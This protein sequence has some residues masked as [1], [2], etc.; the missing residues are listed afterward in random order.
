MISS[1]YYDPTL[2]EKSGRYYVRYYDPG[3]QPCMVERALGTSKKRAAEK[4]LQERSYAYLHGLY[5]PWSEGTSNN[6]LLSEAIEKYLC[7]PHLRESTVRSKRYRLEPLSRQHPYMLVSGLTENII[8]EYCMRSDL[9]SETRSRYLYE[10]RKFLAFCGNQNWISA[11]PAKNILDS[12]PRHVKREKRTVYE[13]L[14]HEEVR[15]LIRAIEADIEMN[16]RRE[17][18][19]ILTDIILI[20]VTTGLRRGELCGLRWTDVRF[21]HSARLE[22]DESKG[23]GWIIVRGDESR[24]TK[25]GDEDRVPLVELSYE[26][27]NTRRRHSQSS[28]FVFESPRG[29]GQVDGEWISKM[30][31]YYRRLAKLPDSI[32]FHSLRHT[33]ASWLA[34]SGVDIKVIQEILRH[35]NLKQ[36][37]RY[38]HLQPDYVAGQ[39]RMALNK[40][41]AL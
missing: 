39:A 41:H 21:D 23:Y 15:R 1:R 7:D 17:N 9:K 37:L 5:D 32:H 28:E 4:F 3:K 13:F 31:R 34:G 20:A 29:T 35:T 24:Q 19:R 33:C 30:F 27:L 38:M 22:A 40:F 18:R 16:P 12:L 10:I 14:T 11:N 25:T 6:V 26:I 8:R 36:T 2:R